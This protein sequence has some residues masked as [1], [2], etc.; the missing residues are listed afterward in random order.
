MRDR[1][2]FPGVCQQARL[3]ITTEH[4]DRVAVTASHQNKQPIR[5]DSEVTRMDSR[6]L[7]S[8]I[9]QKAGGRILAEYRQP[10]AFQAVARIKELPVWREMDV[11]A[12]PRM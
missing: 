5:R 2:V 9:S 11:C 1:Y 10:V 3:R 8:N 7:I 4:L 12:S 6:V